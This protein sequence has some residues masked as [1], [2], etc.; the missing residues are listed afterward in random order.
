MVKIAFFALGLLAPLATTWAQTSSERSSSEARDMAEYK[1]VRHAIGV[2]GFENQAGYAGWRQLGANLVPMLEAA[3]F[4]TNRFVIVDRQELDDVVTEQQLAGSGLSSGGAGVAQ[5]GQI[6]AAKYVATG[7]VTR[8]DLQ[9]EGGDRR[10]SI[11][12][13]GFGRSQKRAELELVVRLV[14]TST[15][16]V[17][18]QE[19]ITGIA[20]SGG[21]SF[22]VPGY[23]QR[24]D[25]DPDLSAAAQDAIVKAARFIAEE[26][27]DYEITASVV[28]VRGSSIVLSSG[29]SYGVAVGDEFDIREK[30]E[31]LIHPDTGEILDVFEGE[32]TG[33]VRVKRVSDKVSYADLISGSMPNRGDTVVFSK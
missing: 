30:G 33:R 23:Q 26:M 15:G 14:D 17:A 22:T 4:E 9:S 21:K 11:G 3:L 24:G 7:A 16:E 28:M 18:A 27:E 2:T 10:L 20:E 6:R 29:E 32:V 25:V 13:F 5:Q 1:G 19:R 12:G 31:V 8:V